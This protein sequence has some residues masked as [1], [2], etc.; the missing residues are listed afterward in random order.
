M[1]I[2]I[3]GTIGSGKT[4]V[5]GILQDLGFKIIDADAIG[6]EI[7]KRASI[8][9]KIKKAFGSLILEDKGEIDRKKLGGIVFEDLQKLKEL[10]SITHPKIFA[11]IKKQVARLRLSDNTAKIILE[12]ALLLGSGSKNIVDRI[13]LVTASKEDIFRRLNGKYPKD[14]IERILKVQNQ[15]NKKAKRADYIIENDGNITALK[16]K[17]KIIATKLLA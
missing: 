9:K 17:V 7:L 13:I 1:I 11:Q 16:K 3:A 5:A 4:T 8:K 2:G 6:H 14:R 12:S 15:I 10:N